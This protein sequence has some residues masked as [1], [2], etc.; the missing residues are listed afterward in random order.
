MHP[1]VNEW[2]NFMSFIL[3]E[4]SW[5]PC[6]TIKDILEH[7]WN[8]MAIPE[9]SSCEWDPSRAELYRTNKEEFERRAREYSTKYTIP[10]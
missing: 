7:I 6:L 9:F 8:I 4:E 10:V 3:K 2:G 1:N 5:S